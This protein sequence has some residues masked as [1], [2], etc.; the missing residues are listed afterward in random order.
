MV[1]QDPFETNLKVLV[2]HAHE[3]PTGHFRPRQYNDSTGKPATAHSS[4]SSILEADRLRCGRRLQRLHL[5]RADRGRDAVREQLVDH[6]EHRH[7]A[8]DLVSVTVAFQAR[9]LLICVCSRLISHVHTYP[10]LG[11]K[12]WC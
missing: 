2:Q 4:R 9:S 5:G 8:R 6:R 1:N 3:L 11:T 12:S 7:Y 10:E